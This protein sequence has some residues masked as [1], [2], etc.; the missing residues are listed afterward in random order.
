MCLTKEDMDRPQRSIS[1]SGVPDNRAERDRGFTK[2]SARSFY[3]MA[4]IQLCVHC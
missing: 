4:G 1:S 2:H 3:R